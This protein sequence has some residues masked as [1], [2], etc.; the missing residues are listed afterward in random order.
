MLDKIR[1]RY[2]QTFMLTDFAGPLDQISK[3]GMLW[4]TILNGMP[5]L[6]F[7]LTGA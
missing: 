5:N 7:L 4:G 6:R 1:I 2:Q 3:I